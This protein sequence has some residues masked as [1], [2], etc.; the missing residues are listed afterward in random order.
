MNISEI[1]KKRGE[2]PPHPKPLFLFILIMFPQH[3]AF[4]QIY[5]KMFT[6]VILRER[7]GYF[8]VK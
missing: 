3:F 8:Y 4:F 2:L 5:G 6:I 1:N 7:H